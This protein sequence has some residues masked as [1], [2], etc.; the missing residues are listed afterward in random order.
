MVAGGETT[1]MKYYFG[2]NGRIA[3][4]T[5]T[6][7][8]DEL[9]YIHTDHLGSAV[10]MTN[11]TG[12]IVHSIAYDLF[13][14]TVYSTGSKNP[15][16]QF[17]GQEFDTEIGL[18]YYGARYYDPEMGRFI[19]A[20]TML[21]GLNRYTYCLN[22]PIIYTDPSGHNPHYQPGDTIYGED[23][24]EYTVPDLPTGDSSG[25]G[26]NGNDSGNF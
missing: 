9:L 8:E 11:T 13:G 21:A 19:Q 16:Y 15:S 17:T 2:P 6:D 20:D 25:G 5:K 14:K 10:R 26:M 7:T 24:Y 4:R 18:Y 23:G 22:N 1:K 12:D 3:Q